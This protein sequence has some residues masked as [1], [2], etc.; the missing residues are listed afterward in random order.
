MNQ[1]TPFGCVFFKSVVKAKRKALQSKKNNFE[2]TILAIIFASLCKCFS[3]R[4]STKSIPAYRFPEYSN[5]VC[6]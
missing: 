4:M 5:T 6:V 3:L 2:D 1:G